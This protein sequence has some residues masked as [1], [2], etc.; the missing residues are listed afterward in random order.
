MGFLYLRQEILYSYDLVETEV[1]RISHRVREL[2]IAQSR[3]LS[4][5][6]GRS[7]LCMSGGQVGH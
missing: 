2:E 3:S 1:W 4:C 6:L 5:P 7:L